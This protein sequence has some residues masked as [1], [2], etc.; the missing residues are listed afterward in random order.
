[1]REIWMLQPRFERRSGRSPLKLLEH[2]RLRAGYDFLLLR[3]A[4][5]EA[6]AELGNWWTAFMHAANP[7]AREALLE[8]A[9]RQET[10]AVA[11]GAAPA[12]KR[13]RRGARRTGEDAPR[14]SGD[15][16]ADA[17]G[18]ADLDDGSRGSA[19]GGTSGAGIARARSHS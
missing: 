7:E 13:R 1:M 11:A 17:Q 16:G 3:C 4:S 15:P 5:G 8:A 14:D 10:G 9:H 18:R 19:V 12:R 6:P 2:M